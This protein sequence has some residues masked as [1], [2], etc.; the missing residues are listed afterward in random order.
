MRNTENQGAGQ[1]PQKM[2]WVVILAKEREVTIHADNINEAVKEANS[3][4]TTEEKIVTI[5]LKR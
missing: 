5:R 3:V 4:K 1:K 2:K